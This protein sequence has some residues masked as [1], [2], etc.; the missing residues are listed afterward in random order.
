MWRVLEVLS[1]WLRK[2]ESIAI[3]LEGIALVA[4]LVLDWR[5][6]IDQRKERQEQH[7][8]SASQMD[9]SRRQVDAAT[10]AALASKKSTE[11]LAG[12]HRPFM[13]LLMV[14]LDA[15]GP[16]HDDWSITFVQKNFGTLPALE[17]GTNIEFFAGDTSF[18]KI[19]EPATIQVFPS[20]ETRI[21]TRQTIL[22]RV[23]IQ[24]GA[25]KLL[26]TVLIPYR[27]EDGRFFEYISQV[28]FNREQNSF[29]I[30]RSD[31]RLRYCVTS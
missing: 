31:T 4:I 12:L 11:I 10:E 5:E 30:D 29:N 1:A 2:Y 20:F 8:E 9:I 16:G 15:G 17:V 25:E 28:S 18:A 23:E 21:T 7:R 24:N 26:I 3:W 27:S 6:R 22:K 19:S 14:R 13:G